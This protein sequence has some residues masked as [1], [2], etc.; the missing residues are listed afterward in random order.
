MLGA[1]AAAAAAKVLSR[2]PAPG[3]AQRAGTVL[4]GAPAAALG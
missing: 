1:A 2:E 3:S 4:S